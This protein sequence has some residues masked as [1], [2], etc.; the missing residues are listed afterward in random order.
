MEVQSAN[1]G[2]LVQIAMRSGVVVHEN[3]VG[4]DVNDGLENFILPVRVAF[5]KTCRAV[6]SSMLMPRP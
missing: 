6:L 4:A 3:E 1:N 5:L 2:F